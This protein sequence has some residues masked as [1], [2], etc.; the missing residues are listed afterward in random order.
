MDSNLA[1]NISEKELFTQIASYVEEYFSKD[2]SN[3]NL[4][5]DLENKFKKFYSK[6]EINASSENNLDIV[7]CFEVFQNIQYNG[8]D[9][10]NVTD[11]VREFCST[12]MVNDINED[13]TKT[14]EDFLDNLPAW[15]ETLNIPREQNRLCIDLDRYTFQNMNEEKEMI[16]DYTCKAYKYGRNAHQE[17]IRF[18]TSVEIAQNIKSEHYNGFISSNPNLITFLHIMDGVLDLDELTVYKTEK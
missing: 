6:A 15:F 3:D 18:I 13:I 4:L 10:F 17:L 14:L 11:N 7:R 9:K 2:Q 5:I 12:G 8:D 1:N 16:L